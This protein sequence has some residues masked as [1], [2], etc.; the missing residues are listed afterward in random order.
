MTVVAGLSKDGIVYIGADSL[1]ASD[2]GSLIARSAPKVFYRGPV[3]LGYAGDLRAMDVIQYHLEF[4]ID[5]GEV[6]ETPEHFI[7]LEL[8]P[9]MAKALTQAGLLNDFSNRNM[10]SLPSFPGVFLAGYGGE[11]FEIS[12]TLQVTRPLEQFIA[13]GSGEDFAMGSMYSTINEPDYDPRVIVLQALK[14][15]AQYQAYVGPPFGV[16]S[17]DAPKTTDVT[18]GGIPATHRRDFRT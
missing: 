1:V 14:A 15:A 6:F 7:H 16:I 10:P 12:S 2:G 17:S 9:A 3:I 5:E 11:V 8:V 18:F 4:E 13:T